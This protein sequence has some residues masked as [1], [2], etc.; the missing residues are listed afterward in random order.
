[1]HSPIGLARRFAVVAAVF[2][3]VLTGGTAWA[4]VC[5]DCA[6]CADGAACDDGL[7]CTAGETC[8]AGLCVGG[9]PTNE[10]GSCDDGL[11]CTTGEV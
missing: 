8:L 4:Q 5:N 9:L 10:G 2:A 6:A 3:V 7:A 1:M 11:F